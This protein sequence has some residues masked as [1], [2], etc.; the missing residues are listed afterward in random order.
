MAG[1]FSKGNL[2]KRPGAYFNFVARKPEPALAGS[3]GTVGLVGQHSWGP[4]NQVVALNNW[5]E[6]LATYGAGGSVTGAV[7]G[8]YRAVRDAFKG[9]G[10]PGYAGAG[11]VLFYRV[12]SGAVAASKTLQNTTPV[13]ALTLTARYPGTYGNQ[14]TVT[15][16]ANTAD[17]TNKND[18][19]IYVEGSEA[20]RFT[21]AKT[22]I[23]DLA[24]QINGTTP[25]TPA[26]ASDWVTAVSNVTGVAL[27]AVTQTPLTAGTDGAAL[28]PTDYSTAQTAF[29]IYR[30]S[31]FA[32]D[33]VIDPTVIAAQVAWTQLRNSKGR[34]FVSIIGGAAGETMATAVAR[35]A[36]A[37]D[38]NIVNVG[39]GTYTDPDYGDIS[40]AQLV[41]RVAG[42]V[43]QR[44]EGAEITFARL[45]GLTIKVG[46]SDADVVTALGGGT[47]AISRDSHPTAPVR[48]ELGVTTFTTLTDANRS[49]TIFGNLKFVRVMGGIETEL[50]EWAEWNVIGKMPVNDA[51]R[52][53]VRGRVESALTSREGDGIVQ[54]GWKVQV[55]ANPPP[56][57]TDTFVSVD[58]TLTLGRGLQQVL[59]TVT[60]G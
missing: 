19:V 25:Y 51:T 43:A 29:E 14:I 47:V 35:A 17:P 7:T 21:Y 26:L 5:G 34:R 11:Q 45:Q 33:G 38:P 2:P 42:I 59:N 8:G 53:Y 20:E 10:L 18:L 16:T 57:P 31:V 60:V 37:N 55:S 41:P 9:E 36:T 44:G 30:F 58:Y 39:G 27:T 46:I 28:T 13:T 54:P 40:T 1:I 24:A 49:Q 12:A 4:V 6:F 23:A 15:S 48:L 3:I 56:S 22:N 32:L 52:D 50:T